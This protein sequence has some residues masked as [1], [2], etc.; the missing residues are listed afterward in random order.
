MAIR[1]ELPEHLEQRLRASLG[2]LD[3]ATKEAALVELFRQAKLTHHEFAEALGLTRFEADAVLKAHSVTEDLPSPEEQRAEVES[4]LKLV[5][6][7]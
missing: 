5:R 1:F 4:L 3:R 7:R 6:Q 2:N